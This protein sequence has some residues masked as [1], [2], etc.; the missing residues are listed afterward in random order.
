MG[1]ILVKR[2]KLYPVVEESGEICGFYA[3]GDCTRTEVLNVL[4]WEFCDFYLENQQGLESA[5][6]KQCYLR[7][8][9]C[10]P[11]SEMGLAG[12]TRQY[13]ETNKGRGAFL[14]TSIYL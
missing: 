2:V 13:F 9:P 7:I 4:S 10:H 8:V 6:V 3:K 1:I 5:K 11:N 12:F 14:A